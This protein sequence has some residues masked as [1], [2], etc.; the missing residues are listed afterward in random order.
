MRGQA[1]LCELRTICQPGSERDALL[2]CGY[3]HRD[4]VNYIVHLDTSIDVL[5]RRVNK[6][7]R[8]KIR[9]TL[10]KGIQLDGYSPTE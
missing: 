6:N 5:W 4:C 10:R 8:Q 2:L 1:L 7:L 9:A 3:E